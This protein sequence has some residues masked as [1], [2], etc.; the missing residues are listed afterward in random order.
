MKSIECWIPP[1][2]LKPRAT[3]IHWWTLWSI[4]GPT[5]RTIECW[6]FNCSMTS[7][8][9]KEFWNHWEMGTTW[10]SKDTKGKPKAHWQNLAW[11]LRM[12]AGLHQVGTTDEKWTYCHSLNR[13]WSYLSPAW[14]SSRLRRKLGFEKGNALWFEISVLLST[15]SF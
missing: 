13:K 12:K 15:A 9:Q 8:S 5:C 6:P 11:K 7:Q 3:N 1:K 2:R 14:R 4:T 10:A